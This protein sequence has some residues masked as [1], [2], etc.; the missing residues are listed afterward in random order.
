MCR[1]G[2]STRI[3]VVTIAERTLGCRCRARRWA[4]GRCTRR[5]GRRTD[6][7][8]P[9]SLERLVQGGIGMS[10]PVA[11]VLYS[12]GTNSHAE[13]MW[14][15]ERVGATAELLFIS[16]VLAGRERLDSGDLLCIPGGFAYGDH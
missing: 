2:R 12:P 5:R 14:A 13:T 7:R 3:G 11:K 4:W 16:D 1:V 10:R 6:A 8:R 9:V 15:F